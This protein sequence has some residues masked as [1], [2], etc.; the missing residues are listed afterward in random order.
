MEITKSCP[1]CGTPPKVEDGEHD[2]NS[3]V[4][5]EAYPKLFRMDQMFSYAVFCIMCGARGPEAKTQDEAISEWN[6]AK[7]V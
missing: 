4:I 7:W 3:K 6:N 5:Y 2:A 1:F